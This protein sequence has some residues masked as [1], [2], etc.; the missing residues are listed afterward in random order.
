MRLA[1]A[2]FRYFPFGG[3]QRDMLALAQEAVVRGH[4]VTVFC[5]TWQGE[6]PVGIDIVCLQARVWFNT[7]GIQKFVRAFTQT[8]ERDEF[9][10]LLGF[11]KM[12]G[13]DV[14]YCG[15][16][17]F[18]QKAYAER[19][20]FYRLSPRARLYL[21]YERAV[22]DCAAAT[23]MLEVAS[24]ER[25]V[26][27]KYYGTAPERFTL[28]PP[29]LTRSHSLAPHPLAARTQLRAELN[30]AEPV[31]L[32]LC[33]G[34]G[35]KTKGIDRSLAVF[36]QALSCSNQALH[37]WVVGQG[38]SASFRAQAQRLGIAEQVSF[39]G[40]RS[41]MANI[42][43]AADMLLHCAYRE[44]AGNVLLEAMLAGLPVLASSVCGYGHYVLAQNMGELIAEPFDAGTAAQQLL[45]W[46]TT[47]KALLAERAQQFAASGEVFAR[48]QR[49]LDYLEAQQRLRVQQAAPQ[50]R[51]ISPAQQLVL[52]AELAELWGE[53]A[54]L[55]RD[56]FS[57]INTLQGPVARELPDRQTL[58]F[59][60]N[61]RGYYRKLHRGVGWG[62]IIKNVLQLRWPVLGA[63]NE[64]DALNRLQA[65]NIPSLVPLAYG[66]RGSNP[67]RQQSFI[68]TRELT[69][70]VQL[71]H[72]FEQQSPSVQQRR[73]II[74]R[75][76]E[77]ARDL[78]AAGIN[79]R[80]F[81]LC[82]FML[83][84]ESLVADTNG[85]IQPQLFLIDLHR[86][87]CRAQVPLRWRVKDLSGLYFSALNLPFSRADIYR[88]MRIYW[89]QS[90]RQ[91]LAAERALLARIERRAQQTYKRDFGHLPRQIFNSHK[92]L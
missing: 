60:L 42:Y 10:L 28:L 30:V 36:A 61:L 14:Y 63:Q 53:Q 92:P 89:G 50:L 77:L 22:F 26:F 46:L 5:G 59:E 90:L 33:V 16:S 38:D 11:N 67:A 18:A 48:P 6:R 91:L 54:E 66:K 41:D 17:C 82:H 55:G 51:I 40:A 15:D 37:L 72:Y 58:R 43:A 65:L 45:I 32:V 3:L 78:H 70:V 83:K 8:F 68:V 2:I 7:A 87:Q 69:D 29:G 56:I 35:F 13:L 81:Y 86:A 80:D 25:P 74:R 4:K 71:D 21:N 20:W 19:S 44:V 88:F 1:I 75:L 64:W 12:P 31:K 57:L 39:L 49:A 76:A 9:D 27:A 47:D 23:T 52:R 85:R 73:A 84:P 24:A 62:E 34:S 79:H